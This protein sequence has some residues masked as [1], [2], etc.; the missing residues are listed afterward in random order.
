MPLTFRGMLVAFAISVIAEFATL[1]LKLF[2]INPRGIVV[3]NLAKTYI[4]IY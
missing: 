1:L 4:Y 3:A 2:N